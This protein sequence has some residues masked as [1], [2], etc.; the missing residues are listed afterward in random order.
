MQAKP[1][2]AEDLQ[3]VIEQAR[4][5][6]EALRDAHIFI[7]GGTGFFGHWLL[8]SLLAANRELS[9]NAHATVLTRGAENFRKDSP[10]ISDDKFITLLE[11]DIRTFDFPSDNFTHIV[12]AATDSGDEPQRIPGAMAAIV[13]D[14]TKR[15]F[16]FAHAANAKRFLYLSTGAVYGRSTTLLH[17]PE[18]YPLPSLS[19]GSYEA[20]KQAAERWLFEQNAPLE[21]VIARPF[22]FIGPRLPLDAHFA[23]GNFLNAALRNDPI[24]IKGDGT[25]RRSWMYMSDLAAWL[26]TIL[27]R[28]EHHRAYNVGS[29]ESYTIS[30]AAKLTAETLAPDLAVQTL[31]TPNAD[32]P[33]NSYVP[34]INRAQAELSLRTTVTLAE[35]LRK[36]AQWHRS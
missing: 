27:I 36:T 29:E 18:D 16:E 12:H 22:A 9:L 5:S 28:G 26:W 19:S 33:L 32:A 14:G 11:G 17:T 2:P 3:A 20:S 6:F 34:S 13:I 25:P 31:G 23:I 1:L 7:T 8:E 21:V 24:V 15:V 30:E 10:W 4:E 35:A